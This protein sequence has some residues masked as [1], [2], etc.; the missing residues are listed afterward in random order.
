MEIE[1]GIYYFNFETFW[2][3]TTFTSTRCLGAK[4]VYKITVDKY[5][6]CY[7]VH[8]FKSGTWEIWYPP[9]IINFLIKEGKI[10][11]LTEDDMIIRDIIL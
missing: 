10:I 7:N 5:L 1:S 11:K 6:G 3:Q 2:H 8:D 9:E 4:G